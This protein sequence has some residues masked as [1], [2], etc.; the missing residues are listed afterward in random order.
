MLHLTQIINLLFQTQ[1]KIQ[2]LESSLASAIESRDKL[3]VEY[4]M[5]QRLLEEAKEHL[6]EETTARKIS[7]QS[8][9]PCQ[10]CSQFWVFATMRF[11]LESHGSPQPVLLT[12]LFMHSLCSIK[13]FFYFFYFRK[14]A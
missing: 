4:R 10:D 13:S 11:K 12:W 3:Q 8:D 14:I 6:Q 5:S 1:S 7:E 9:L 2:S